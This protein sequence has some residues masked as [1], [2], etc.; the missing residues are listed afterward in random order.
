MSVDRFPRR[1]Y[2]AR[3][4]RIAWRCVRILLVALTAM[5][6]APPPPPLPK[7]EVAE[8]RADKGEERRE[9]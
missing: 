7:R 6:P 5:G 4:G 3:I 9:P 1:S 8:L 2:A